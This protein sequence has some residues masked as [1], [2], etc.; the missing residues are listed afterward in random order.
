M[1]FAIPLSI[2]MNFSFKLF[3]TSQGSSSISYVIA[4][5]TS[6]LMKKYDAAVWAHHELFC[7]G[8]DFGVIN[9]GFLD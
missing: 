4:L 3:G 5:A 8:P 2:T 7:S 1:L 9:E 6:E